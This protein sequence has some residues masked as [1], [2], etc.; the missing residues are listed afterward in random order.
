MLFICLFTNVTPG[1]NST[2]YLIIS[3]VN[4]R[5]VDFPKFLLYFSL[6]LHFPEW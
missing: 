4:L 2:I 5:A 1:E 6:V 3:Y